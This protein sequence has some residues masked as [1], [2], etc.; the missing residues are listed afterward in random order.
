MVLNRLMSPCS[1]LGV[2]R[3]IEEVEEP[4]F[5]VSFQGE[6]LAEHGYPRDR[7]P[8]LGQIVVAV[9]VTREG[10]PIA[11]EVFPGATSD[12]KGF[13]RVITSLKERFPIGRVIFVSGRGTFSQGNL[14]LLS[15][16]GLS[17]IMGV[18]MRRV[19][20]VAVAYK[21]LWRVEAVHL[22]VKGKLYLVRTELSG[23]SGW[24]YLP[25]WWR[26]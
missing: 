22:E 9:A 4:T 3:W 11:H 17:Y 25:G 20:E 19:R 10:V 13:A 16:L 6:G 7:R 5:T 12:I 15:E 23:R 21:G 2:S 26:A 8:D 24:P 1:K 14:S 18:R